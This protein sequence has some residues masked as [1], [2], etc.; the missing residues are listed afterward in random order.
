MDK[1]TVAYTYNGILLSLKMENLTQATIW[2]KLEN[3]PSEIGSSQKNK[4]YVISLTQGTKSSQA[5]RQK[6]EWWLPGDKGEGKRGVIFQ[7]V[8]FQS[9]QMKKFWR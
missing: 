1:E 9:C 5:H 2:R 7:W 6:A 8:E 4:Y 3:T